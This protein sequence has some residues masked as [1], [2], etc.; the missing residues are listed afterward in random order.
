MKTY[1]RAWWRGIGVVG[2]YMCLSIL[3]TALGLLTEV[4]P[5]NLQLAIGLPFLI[6]FAPPA[7]YW[8]FCW[9]NPEAKTPTASKN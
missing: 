1:L 3:V 6:L 2:I 4:L 8:I 9:L 7:F 5:K